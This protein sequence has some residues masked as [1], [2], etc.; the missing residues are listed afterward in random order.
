MAASVDFIQSYPLNNNN[1]DV[2]ANSEDFGGTDSR[3]DSEDTE[4]KHDFQDEK[5]SESNVDSPYGSV[6][7]ENDPTQGGFFPP[8]KR[9]SRK[10]RFR[11]S[12]FFIALTLYTCCI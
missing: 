10:D 12:Y 1:T 2:D 11:V 7:S 3:H 5:F 8:V 6:V 4:S 9:R